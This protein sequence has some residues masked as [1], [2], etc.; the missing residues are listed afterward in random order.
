MSRR[1]ESARRAKSASVLLDGY[2]AD[3]PV[4][5]LDLLDPYI[6]LFAE[7]FREAPLYRF[8]EDA[9]LYQKAMKLGMANWSTTTDLT[10]PEG[11]IFVDRSL[12]GHFGN[13]IRMQATGPWREILLRYAAAV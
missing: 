6:D 11:V 9:D 2:A 1:G 8:G 7:I 5:E 12:A 13:L 4:L 10:F 3:S